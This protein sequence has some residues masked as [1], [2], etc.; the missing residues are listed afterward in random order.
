MKVRWD[1]LQAV[2]RRDPVWP[3]RPGK[4]RPF[5][6]IASTASNSP[7]D[8]VMRRAAPASAGAPRADIDALV[9][10]NRTLSWQVLGALRQSILTC[11]SS[12]RD[13]KGLVRRGW[14]R[15]DSGSAQLP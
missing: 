8:R 14:V 1:S 11:A 4:M 6:R 2:T 12:S 10:Q 5:D 15:K 9:V 7:G 3:R 13:V